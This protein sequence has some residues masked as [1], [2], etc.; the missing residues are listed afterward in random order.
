MSA[1]AR[2]PRLRIVAVND[3]YSLENLPRL[4]S[5]VRQAAEVDPAD[6]LLITMAGDF[7]APSL[8]SSLDAGRAMV[9]CMN[10][11]GFTHVIFGN[12]EDD[13][14]PAELRARVH[15]LGATCLGTNVHGFEPA[16]PT[17]DLVRVRAGA[18][19]VLVGLVGVVMTDPTV[20]R[21]APFGGAKLTPPT[22]AA[23][24]E[25]RQLEGVGCDAV[26]AL[27]H[28]PVADDRALAR[29]QSATGAPFAVL[30]AGHEHQSSLEREGT[31]WIVKGGADAALAALVELEWPA[32][33]GETTPRVRVALH[34]VADY[35]EDAALRARVNKHMA[36]VSALASA[37]L[38]VLGPGE[39]LSSVGTRA[40]QTTLGEL[41]ASRIRDALGAEVGLFNGGGVRGAKTYRERFSYGDLEAEVPF[42]NEMVVVPLPGAVLAEAVRA[43]RAHAP[44]ESGG[45]LQVCSA[46][47]VGADGEVTHIGGAP[48]DHARSY[49]VALVRNLFAGMDHIGPL[50]AFARQHP[51]RI[52]P[53][54]SGRDVKLVLLESFAASL[55]AE[56]G[57]FDRV[58]ADHDGRVT[59]QELERAL[60]VRHEAPSEIAA[61][62]VL[63]ALDTNRDQVISREEADAADAAHKAK[64]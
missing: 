9:D 33:G 53:L 49:H 38:L 36:R 59:A 34:D 42:E 45:F 46:V 5:L 52:P 62:I 22:P 32:D 11:I 13:L 21:R 57:G 2:G 4:R 39:S 37:T 1:P 50:V 6:A 30:L 26:L 48:L 16:L 43:S 40:R 41:L 55:W 56:L 23:L 47:A 20:Y 3:V 18:R 15:E 12:H 24:E 60:T 64:R 28:Q 8:L 17:S 29:A 19:E 44:V 51:E 7:L 58:D 63:R 31:T 10:A 54:G 25:A 35:P 61:G 27:T 14:A